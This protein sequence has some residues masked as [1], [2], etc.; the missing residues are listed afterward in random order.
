MVVIA[1]Q[2]A[3]HEKSVLPARTEGRG[4]GDIAIDVTEKRV[5]DI[6][7]AGAPEMELGRLGTSASPVSGFYT[8]LPEVP[9]HLPPPPAVWWWIARL[10]LFPRAAD[11]GNKST[12]ARP[13]WVKH[14]MIG[15]RVLMTTTGHSTW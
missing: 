9:R 8:Q 13:V 2:M 5:T 10:M 11:S 1:I 6:A 15:W 7:M 3:E 12:H 14:F 4:D